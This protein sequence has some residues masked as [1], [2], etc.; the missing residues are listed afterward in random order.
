ME[1]VTVQGHHP[2]RRVIFVGVGPPRT[3]H[4]TSLETISNVSLHIPT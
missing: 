1:G 2:E 4:R 3:D